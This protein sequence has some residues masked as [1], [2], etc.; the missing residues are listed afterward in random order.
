MAD[1]CDKAGDTTDMLNGYRIKELQARSK[2]RQLHPTGNCYYC[3]EVIDGEK[4]F[5]DKACAEDW[6][7]IMKRNDRIRRV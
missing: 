1:I 5:C 3:N 7:L 2:T 4:L 6:E